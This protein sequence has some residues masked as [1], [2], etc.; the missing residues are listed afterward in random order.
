MLFENPA[1]SA[2]SDFLYKAH[3][4][5]IKILLDI[6]YRIETI[7]KD[8]KYLNKVLE[9]TNYLFGSL[10]DEI[11][12]ISYTN[13]LNDALEKLVKKDR[14]VIVRNAKG[15]DIYTINNHYHSD[16]YMVDVVDTTGAGDSYNAGFIYG[17][18]NNK[19]L[20]ICNKFGCACAGIN[21]E[22]EGAR[23]TPSESELFK[24]ISSH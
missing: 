6:N 5:G 7:D 12:P 15:S 16:S 19:S 9:I 22:K 21:I 3:N 13:N 20:D 17:L 8:R 10:E 2:I 4:L 11:L 1:A 18:V 14:T 24:F 23:N